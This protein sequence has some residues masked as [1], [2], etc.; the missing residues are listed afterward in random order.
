MFSIAITAWSANVF[1]SAI[2]LPVKGLGCSRPTEMAPIGLPSRSI[3]TPS[4]L[5]LVMPSGHGAIVIGVFEHVGHVHD[6]A[7]EESPRV[8]VVARDRMASGKS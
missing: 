4:V 2:C 6:G 1:T 3:G 8:I 7:V 5:R